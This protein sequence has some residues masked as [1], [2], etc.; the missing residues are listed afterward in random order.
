ML[1]LF[2][3]ISITLTF[4]VL[5]HN[6]DENVTEDELKKIFSDH[7]RFGN[8]AEVINL[9]IKRKSKTAIIQFR[10]KNSKCSI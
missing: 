6:L 4:L 8:D 3:F 10:N 2:R 1:P 7:L 9:T 5:I